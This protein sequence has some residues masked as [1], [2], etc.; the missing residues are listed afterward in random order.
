VNQHRLHTNGHGRRALLRSISAALL[1]TYP[2]FLLRSQ[3]VKY[4]LLQRYY[5]EQLAILEARRA[6]ERVP[7]YRD[8]IDAQCGGFSNIERFCDLPE[9]NKDLYI[10]P[11]GKGDK[12]SLYVDHAIP[13]GSSWDTSTGTSGIPT[14]WYRGP[15]EVHAAHRLL[16]HRG[17][18]MIGSVP[19]TVINAFALG[20]WATGMTTAR[21]MGNNPYA[22]TYNVGAQPELILQLIAESRTIAPERPIVVC[23][24]PPHIDQVVKLARSNGLPLHDHPTIAVVGGEALSELQRARIKAAPGCTVSSTGFREVYSFYGASDIDINIGMETPYEIALRDVLERNNELARH[25]LGES[26]AFVP[27]IFSYD[28]LSHLIEVNQNS[29]LLFTEVSGNRI[30]PRIRY[31]LDKGTIRSAAEVNRALADF[32]ITIPANRICQNPFVFVWGR[33]DDGITYRGAN[34]AWENLEAA[35]RT[36]GLGDAIQ[37][38]GLLQYEDE[39]S[40]RTEFMLHVS[41]SNS[42]RHL[43]E[44]GQDLLSGLTKAVQRLNH[45][46]SYQIEH[47]D[48]ADELPGLRLYLTDSPMAEHS[49]QNPARKQKHIFVGTEAQRAFEI[50]KGGVLIH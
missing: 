20:P 15:R 29:Q 14:S 43:E 21:A 12:R 30:S 37:F 39:D 47:L 45:D 27:M 10:K 3:V 24:Y 31:N 33:I 32:G 6:Y 19:I 9:T 26:M 46:F 50:E 48:D 23:G 34:L 11:Y 38:F 7:A 13:P 35:L 25:L 18:A 36:L 16:A 42:F 8:Y 17:K 4:P 44:N 22:V 2:G 28:P 41:D 1:E 40:L 5:S 49:R